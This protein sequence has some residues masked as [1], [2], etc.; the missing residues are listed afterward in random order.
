MLRGEVQQAKYQDWPEHPTCFKC[1]LPLIPPTTGQSVPESGITPPLQ[2]L[3]QVPGSTLP[4]A[5]GLKDS[6]AL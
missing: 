6:L 1:P 2:L 3:F 5:H 4:Q